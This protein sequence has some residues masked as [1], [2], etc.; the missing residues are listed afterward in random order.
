[1]K[2]E[3]HLQRR[4][5]SKPINIPVILSREASEGSNQH[6]K[7]ETQVTIVTQNGLQPY[8]FD[9]LMYTIKRAIMI[10]LVLCLVMP[11]TVLHAFAEN[12]FGKMV[13]DA[14]EYFHRTTGFSYS[15]IDHQ[16]DHHV[17]WWEDR[18]LWK[19]VFT[20]H[21]IYNNHLATACQGHIYNGKDGRM[22][23]PLKYVVLFDSDCIL[24]ENED[25]EIFPLL[26]ERYMTEANHWYRTERIKEQ[27]GYNERYG[28]IWQFWPP[29]IKAAFYQEYGHPS[30]FFN[31]VEI[32]SVEKSVLPY[33][34]V[35][36]LIQDYVN[37]NELAI[38]IIEYCID[39]SVI[40]LPCSEINDNDPTWLIRLYLLDGE[41]Y[42]Q[43]YMIAV[44]AV[45]GQIEWID[46]KNNTFIDQ[47]SSQHTT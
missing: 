16:F 8:T 2:R 47:Y 7:T 36:K 43:E 30:G 14:K 44:C 34:A 22:I 29:E 11:N 6:E 39:S 42:R 9:K 19:V 21:D 5:V 23:E 4:T 25:D 20:Y 17:E 35:L 28:R 3:K 27:K 18:E 31:D 33:E 26:L 38:D 32:L 40:M 24:L 41:E 45:H 46:K 1:M 15:F 10:C 12:G 37:A 13:Y